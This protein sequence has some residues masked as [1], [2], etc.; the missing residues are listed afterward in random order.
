MESNLHIIAM[1]KGGGWGVWGGEREGRAVRC[2]PGCTR[3]KGK[4][5]RCPM[6]QERLIHL[7]DVHE[8]GGR[9]TPGIRTS[10]K[11]GIPSRKI[12]KRVGL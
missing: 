10:R 2:R 11:K 5:V 1:K 6:P 8:R 12:R 7:I 3:G 9:E 4:L